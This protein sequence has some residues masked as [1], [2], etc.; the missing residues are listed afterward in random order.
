MNVPK[1]ALRCL[2]L[3]LTAPS[4]YAQQEK[5]SATRLREVVIHAY[6]HDRD[7]L[8]AASATGHID[9]LDL[10]SL[11]PQS[12]VQSVNTIPGV[13]MEERS[14]S[15]YR[16]NIR[17]SS[18]RSPFGIRNVKVYIN[19]LPFTQPG[20]TTY[21]NQLGPLQ[22]S[23]AEIIKGPGGSMYGSGTGGVVLLQPEL[24]EHNGLKAGYTFGSYGLHH[25]FAELTQI[26]SKATQHISY[27][28]TI[29]SG[30]RDQSASD[31]K[32]VQWSSSNRINAQQKIN[33]TFLLG[34]LH[35]ETPGAL[36]LPEY[37]RA[38]SAARPAG[39]N[40]PSAVAAKASIDQSMFWWGIQLQS[41]LGWGIRNKTGIYAGYSELNNAAIRNYAFNQE[42]YGGVRSVFSMNHNIGTI[43]MRTI[44][45]I[46]WQTGTTATDVYDNNL[47]KPSM[48]QSR[49]DI[50]STQ[51]FVFAQASFS[52]KSWELLLGLSTNTAIIK[53]QQRDQAT[54]LWERRFSNGLMPRIS[55]SRSLGVHTFAYVAFAKGFSPP[56][57]D[58]LL[59][60]GSSFN[61]NLQPEEGYNYEAGFRLRCPPVFTA[62][63]NA[64]YFTLQHTIVQRRDAGGGD[65]YLNAGSTRQPG[66]ELALH[67]QNE[68]AGHLKYSFRTSYAFQ[69]YYYQSFVREQEDY[70]GNVL[71]GLAR[72]NLFAA[73]RLDIASRYLLRLNYY[74]N[75]A[76]PLN[77]ANTVYGQES[78][79]LA[80]KAGISLF[81]KRS[82]FT[83]YVGADNL[84]DQQYSMGYDINAAGGR[85]YNAASPRNYYLQLLLRL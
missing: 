4:L 2:L 41:D 23:G 10:E 76:I 80:A 71:P 43:S 39:G 19:D 35:Y 7:G 47:G 81:V 15:S 78:H 13:H 67:Y 53:Y 20:G 31:R 42:P 25:F 18:L 32:I 72:H 37:T 75:S 27:Q 11:N 65:Y 8:K 40:F 69:P 51:G 52:W 21:L 36:T 26:N 22:F 63:I 64:Y 66:I 60:S 16:L 38:P 83:F 70:S 84:L 28:Q 45:G 44:A 9:A 34:D 62:E 55:L 30:Y 6:G 17:G 48:V 57:T 77:D 74:Y 68:H 3:S 5:D 54:D 49:Q 79:L 1:A 56:A 24:Q 73:A 14:P 46:E 33:I 29:S 58:E 85:Y 50:G 82:Q 59:P 61:S 12:A